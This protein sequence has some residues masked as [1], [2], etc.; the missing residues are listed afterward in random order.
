[1][2]WD[3][4]QHRQGGCSAPGAKAGHPGPIEGAGGPHRRH[5]G[6]QQRQVAAKAKTHTADPQADLLAQLLAQ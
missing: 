6:R 2:A 5:C 1:M 3:L 4:G